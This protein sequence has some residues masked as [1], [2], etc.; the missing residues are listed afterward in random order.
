MLESD[1]ILS[2]GP[3]KSTRRGTVRREDQHGLTCSR[4]HCLCGDIDETSE[5]IGNEEND[6]AVLIHCL[7]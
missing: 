7:Q 1:P 4:V 6:Q 3:C 2:N 5:K